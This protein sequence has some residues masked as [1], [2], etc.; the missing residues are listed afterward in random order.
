MA[1]RVRS[2]STMTVEQVNEVFLRGRGLGLQT[3]RNMP[4]SKDQDWLREESAAPTAVIDD[5]LEAM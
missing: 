5:A 3:E 1:D 2:F 4:T